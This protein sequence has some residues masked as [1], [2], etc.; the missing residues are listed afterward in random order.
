MH[1]LVIWI[2]NIIF[3]KNFHGRLLR[4]A[5]RC[6]EKLCV[7][8]PDDLTEMM[9]K[10]KQYVTGEARLRPQEIKTKKVSVA[11]ELVKRGR[12][13][14]APILNIPLNAELSDILPIY[15]SMKEYEPARQIR[16]NKAPDTRHFCAYHKQP[17]HH[18]DRCFTLRDKIN[19]LIMEGKLTQFKKDMGSMTQPRSNHISE[20]SRRQVDI[21]GV[22]EEPDEED[23][24]PAI[25]NRV[26]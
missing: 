1:F 23:S 24:R 12:D 5:Y 20:S 25:R 18:T 15:E 17:G 9:M 11:E 22:F 13:N 3:E 4:L 19:R 10:V 16:Y 2:S 6:Y 26:R 8:R 21:E 7:K 14:R